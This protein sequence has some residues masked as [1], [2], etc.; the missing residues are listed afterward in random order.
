MRIR[1]GPL[2]R[3]P[4]AVGLEETALFSTAGVG[5]GPLHFDSDYRL[6]RI[7]YQ[8]EGYRLKADPMAGEKILKNRKS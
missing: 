5:G 1:H 8:D 6:V 4:E 2:R 7:V 3:R